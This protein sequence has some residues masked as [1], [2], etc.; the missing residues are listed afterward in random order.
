MIESMAAGTPV[1]AL[2]RGSVP[3]V[4]ED[5]VSGFICDDVE[6]M[7]DA[8]GRVGD[9]DPDA[10]RRRAETFSAEAMC[11]GYVEVYDELTRASSG[12]TRIP[13]Q[14]TERGPAD[15][16]RRPAEPRPSP[17]GQLDNYLTPGRG[18]T[19]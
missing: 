14:R 3:E 13:G 1:I 15:R 17:V 11:R 9:I 10:C 12:G 2:R 16:L 6:E 19:P 7:V 18:S 4:I 5:G 8:V